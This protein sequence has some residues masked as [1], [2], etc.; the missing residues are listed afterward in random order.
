MSVAAAAVPPIR[1]TSSSAPSHVKVQ[2]HDAED[3]WTSPPVWEF[4]LSHKT[5]AKA[6]L[7]LLKLHPALQRAVIAQGSLDFAQDQTGALLARIKKIRVCDFKAMV[8][9][10]QIDKIE[11][12]IVQQF[13]RLDA[14]QQANVMERGS[15]DGPAV[16]DVNAVMMNRILEVQYGKDHKTQRLRR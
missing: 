10:L 4:L 1:G 9:L 15:P 8:L 5:E 14:R 12:H 2:G 13:V 3:Q 11:S 7:S 6:A 16:R